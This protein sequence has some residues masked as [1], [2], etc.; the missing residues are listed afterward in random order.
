MKINILTIIFLSLFYNTGLGQITKPEYG[1]VFDE[2]GATYDIENADFVPDS[3]FVLKA[4]FDIDY[5]PKDSLASN[6]L[7][8]S[9]H[10]Y[11]NMHVKNGVKE[12]NISLAFVLHGASTKDA[13]TDEAYM[14]KYGIKNPNTNLIR[15]LSEHRV[16]MYI[17]G[18]SATHAGISKSE[19]LPEIKLALSAMTV[20]TIYQSE[21]YSLIKF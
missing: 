1:P 20:L 6:S 9:L 18:Q 14:R 10:R 8:S 5:M 16:E 4:I 15:T 17:C 11:L 2:I 19:I 21:G 13:L 12:S 7:I 3:T